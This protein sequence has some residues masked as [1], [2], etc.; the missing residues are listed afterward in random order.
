MS[1]PIIGLNLLSHTM[2]AVDLAVCGGLPDAQPVIA[3]LGFST[4]I[5]SLLLV[6]MMG[7]LI[8]TVALVSRAYGAGDSER[9]NHLLVQGTMLTAIVGIVLGVLGAL[10]ASPILRALGASPE[11]AELGT[12]YLRPLMLSTPFAYLALLYAFILRGVGNTRLPFICAL[13]A[14]LVNLALAYAL[15]LGKFGMPMM[16]V[17]GAAASTVIAQLVNV[18]LLVTMLR[19]GKIA[20]LRLPLRIRRIDRALASELFRVGWPAT[21]ESL[22]VNAGFLTALGLLGRFDE[23]AVAAHAIGM[24]VQSLVYVP[25]FGVSQAAA[26][27]VGQALGAGDVDGAR[28]ILRAT[29]WVCSSI[30]FGLMVPILFGARP[31]LQLFDIGSDMRLETYAVEWM[32]LLAYGM[33]PYGIYFAFSAVLSG[34]GATRTGLRINIASTLLVQIPAA[35]ILAVGFDLGPLGVW[36]SFPIMFVMKVALAYRAY[37]QG[38]W[39]VTGTKVPARA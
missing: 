11:L 1:L 35:L 17:Q 22:V 7:L 20:N 14:N 29:L 19:S 38:H 18:G 10:L 26:A 25:A 16:G 6:A 33:V 31:L 9:V 27:L 37:R 4:Q 13:V 30:M 39:A 24:R 3:A 2:L 36:L 28:R 12:S 8:G 5:V 32:S 34:S 23:V 15:V 21:V